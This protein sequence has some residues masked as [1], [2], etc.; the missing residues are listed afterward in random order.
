[1]PQC[2]IIPPGFQYNNKNLVTKLDHLSPNV[3]R[4]I[5]S[6]LQ[7]S[8]TEVLVQWTA[9]TFWDMEIPILKRKKLAS[10]KFA[11]FRILCV[12]LK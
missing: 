4:Q 2:R 8:K 9:F 7:Q 11:N 6:S 12:S 1:M 5:E 3:I 10:V